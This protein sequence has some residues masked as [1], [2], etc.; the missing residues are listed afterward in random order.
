MFWLGL[1]IG[2]VVGV[3]VG[4]FVLSLCIA[5]KTDDKDNCK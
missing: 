4:I 3:V 5:A 1:I 2:L